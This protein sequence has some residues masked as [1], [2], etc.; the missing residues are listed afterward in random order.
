MKAGSECVNSTIDQLERLAALHRAGGLS[1]A[2]YEQQKAR[3]LGSG[4]ATR[5]PGTSQPATDT[6]PL[7]E[8]WQRRFAFFERYGSPFQPA[9]AKALRALPLGPQLSISFNVWA[10]LF[11]P[12]YFAV[13]GVWRRGLTLFGIGCVLTLAVD[14][15]FGDKA[16][17]A[18]GFGWAAMFA[19][20]ANYYRFI[21]VTQG[22][23]E[24]NPLADLF[25]KS[26]PVRTD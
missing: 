24:W 10:Y 23:D 5:A 26:A 8:A 2:E 18:F 9:A 21:K 4:A 6:P 7:S 25:P 11:G 19:I 1:D 16:S 17:S 22:R 12:I 15:L 13:I 14:N 20:S 3:V